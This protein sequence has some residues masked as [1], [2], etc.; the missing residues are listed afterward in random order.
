MFPR[1]GAALLLLLVLSVTINYIDRGAL[2][3]SAPLITRDLNLTTEE[4]GLLLSAF[5]WTYA[6]FQLVSGWLVDRFPVKWVFAVGFLVWSLATAAVGFVYSLPALLLARFVLGMGE[7]VAYPAYGKIVAK[8]FPE[9]S[10]GLAN[11]AID[12]GSKCGPGLSTLLGGLAVAAFGWRGVFIAIGL[13]SLLWLI[14]WL[15]IAPANDGP[16]GEHGPTPSW[17]DLLSKRPV[18]ITSLGMFAYGYTNY[19]TLTWLPSYF[20]KERGFSME[21]MA[22]FGSIPY[23]TMAV[24]SLTCG[25]A[26]DRLIR[27]GYSASKVRRRFCSIGLLLCGLAMFPAPMVPSATV[28]LIL[29]TLACAAVGGFSSNVWAVTQTLS[30]APAA[31]RWTGFQNFVG[32]LGGVAAPLVTGWIVAATGSFLFTFWT[33]AAI[34]TLGVAAYTV[35]LPNMDPVKWEAR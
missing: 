24:S 31:G 29:I 35:L 1:S 28:S 27:A 33:A 8:T 7:S 32:N 16:A 20:I 3:I 11:A 22:T 15:M 9:A 23:W 30:G 34:L 10:R 14:P 6:T 4:M 25:W 18:W 12:A 26:S 13:G 17:G 2:S 19:F 5:F 21:E